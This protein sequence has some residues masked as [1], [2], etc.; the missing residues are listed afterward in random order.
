M[1]SRSAASNI[2]A[3]SCSVGTR[4][5]VLLG[6]SS[7]PSRRRC[8]GSSCEVV[9]LRRV[10]PLVPVLHTHKPTQI[11][12]DLIHS[13][14]YKSKNFGPILV[15]K[16]NGW[17]YMR[18]KLG[19]NFCRCHRGALSSVDINSCS[20]W[21][22]LCYPC[23]LLPSNAVKGRGIYYTVHSRRHQLRLTSTVPLPQH[24]SCCPEVSWPLQL[25]CSL[26]C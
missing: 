17:T 22:Q 16:A 3:S 12:Q 20:V 5:S 8:W 1:S 26:W 2:T 10:L 4:C 14:V 15:L 24:W 11:P 25:H 9:E 13:I 18:G 6:D 21:L 23:P 19:N 7:L